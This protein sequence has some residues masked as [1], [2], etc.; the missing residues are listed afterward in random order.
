MLFNIF[1]LIAGLG[2]LVWSADKFVYGAAAFARN[3]GLPP[4]LI[5]LTIVAMGSSAPEMFVAATASMEGMT[6]TAIGNVLGSNVA[7]IT[8]IL[9]ITALLGAI[10]VSSQTLKREIP[11]MLAAT[12]I[13]GY[14]L[15][16]GQ[17]TRIEGVMLMTLFFGLMGYLIWHAVTN[18]EVDKLADDADS[19]IPKDVPTL[20]AMLWLVVGIILLPMSADWMVQGAVGIAKAYH[21][22]DLVIGLTI[23]A[24]G[25]SLP[26]LAACVAGVL[27]KEDDLAIGNIVGSNLFNILAVLA[28]PALIAPGAVDAAA[29]SRDFYMVMATSSALAIL[30]LLTGKARQLKPWHGGLLLVTFIAYQVVLFQS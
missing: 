11:M 23:I 16:D 27:K 21:L 8:L 19:E 30:I 24:V 18:K 22:S 12:A 3:L 14:F 9:G 6:D 15:H 1:L 29:S 10:S 7:N 4:M 17:L 13:A 25:T 5:G 28:L 20:K 2:A 26:E